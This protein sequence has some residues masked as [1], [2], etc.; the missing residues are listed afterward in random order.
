VGVGK[1]CR[2]SESVVGNLSCVLVC[3]YVVEVGFVVVRVSVGSCHV[4]GE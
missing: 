2:W 1:G 3:V 4:S